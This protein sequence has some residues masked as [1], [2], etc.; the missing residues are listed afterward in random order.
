MIQ[1][2]GVSS[3][4]AFRFLFRFFSQGDLA[5]A[6]RVYG[7]SA[8]FFAVFAAGG[9]RRFLSSVVSALF[10]S[11]AWAD[12]SGLEVDFRE[13]HLHFLLSWCR[14]KEGAPFG[15]PGVLLQLPDYSGEEEKLNPALGFRPAG[16]PVLVVP[17]GLFQFLNHRLSPIDFCFPFGISPSVFSKS[18]SMCVI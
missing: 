2:P 13:F 1:Y 11:A 10:L 17:D 7:T 3:D 16:L 18:L 4:S 14:L 12:F 15:A 9:C 8:I 6:V 5:F